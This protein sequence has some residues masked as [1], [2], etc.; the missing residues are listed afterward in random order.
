MS[1]WKIREKSHY[2]GVSKNSLSYYWK[3]LGVVF[4]MNDTQIPCRSNVRGGWISPYLTESFSHMFNSIR[5][6]FGPPLLICSKILLT[7]KF[8]IDSERTSHWGVPYL[9]CLTHLMV[10]RL[11]HVM[12]L[13]ALEVDAGYLFCISNYLTLSYILY[14]I[15]EYFRN[16]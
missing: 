3:S 8:P 6:S 15:C 2:V 12:H 9:V 13:F 11:I 10:W 7:T 4:F 14:Y 5:H 1:Q 16:K